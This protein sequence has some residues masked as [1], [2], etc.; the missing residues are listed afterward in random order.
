MKKFFKLFVV[1]FSLCLC[2]NVRALKYET[3]ELINVG[4]KATV[5]TELFT[6]TDFVFSDEVDSKGN[7]KI[8]FSSITNKSTEKIPV[9]INILLFNENLKNIGF[10]SYCSD[11]DYSSDFAQFKIASKQSVPFYIN[12]TKRYFQK[13]DEKLKDDEIKNAK[14]VAFYAVLDDNKYCK[15]GGP[16]K[17]RGLTIEEIV[18]GKVVSNAKKRNDY[19]KLSVDFVHDVNAW[20]YVI[21][22]VVVV[23]VSF[24]IQ[25]AILNALYKRMHGKTTGLAYLPIGCNYVS[26][27]LAFGNIVGKIYLIAFFVSVLLS[28]IKIGAIF[29]SILAIISLIS[30]LIVI[31]KLITKKYDLL[32]LDPSNKVVPMATEYVVGDNT[33]TS[34]NMNNNNNLSTN[35]YIMNNDVEIQNVQSVPEEKTVDLNYN[36]NG[37]SNFFNNSNE[38]TTNNNS[39]DNNEGSDLTNLFK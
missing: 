24:V 31:V 10:L 17:Y 9:S 19:F 32:I 6:Y 34:N 3:G 21:A 18:S 28:F 12:V 1:F 20:K 39:N 15:T 14:D 29:L 22:I 30:F 4:E 27:K 23:I 16:T 13:D 25:G 5:D 33:S 2:L 38:N 35:V 26:M 37:T 8:I 7:G 36:D 11:L